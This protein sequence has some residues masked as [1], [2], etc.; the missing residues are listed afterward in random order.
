MPNVYNICINP[1]GI[2]G[3]ETFSRV[4]QKNFPHVRN[5]SFGL[6][7]HAVFDAQFELIRRK[8]VPS[9]K[10]FLKKV[11]L[12]RKELPLSALQKSKNNIFIFNAPIDFDH[13]SEDC[14]KQNKVVYIAH[15]SPEHVDTHGN[16][17]GKNR[18]S[19]IEKL[20]YVDKFISLTSEYET[21]FQSLYKLQSSQMDHF[22]HTTEQ[23]PLRGPKSYINCVGNIC[24][25]DNRAK[26]LDRLL[27]VAD[28][29]PD[30]TFKVFGSGP[31]KEWF[32][33]EANSRSNVEFMGLTDNISESLAEIGVFLVTSDYE[34][35]PISMIEALSQAVPIVVSNNSFSSAKLIVRNGVNGFVGEDFNQEHTKQMIMS[36]F[37]DYAHFSNGALESFSNFDQNAFYEKWCDIFNNL[38]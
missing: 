34:G 20:R 33:A 28:T 3:T 38:A 30:T 37:S 14:F 8:E 2:G 17:F 15:N 32:K 10:V 31:D 22:Y 23:V 26:R 9:I 5:C 35:F 4:L 13:F 25:I 27:A 12:G 16:Y 6:A 1:Q 7:R 18:E 11:L 19:R 21:A 29:M 24:R 36:V